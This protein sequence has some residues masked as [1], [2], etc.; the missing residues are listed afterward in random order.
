MREA[1]QTKKK[2]GNELWQRKRPRRAIFT[3]ALK[4]PRVSSQSTELPARQGHPR[5]PKEAR[6][7]LSGHYL[8]YL[9]S[10]NLA[11]ET[12]CCNEKMSY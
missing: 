2:L 5:G 9:A 3:N 11:S 6:K 4:V 8:A 12:C 7:A 1:S 10:D